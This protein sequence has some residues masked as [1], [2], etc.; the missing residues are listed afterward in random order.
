M[1]AI[2]VD[3]RIV[4]AVDPSIAESGWALF[5]REA[6]GHTLLAAG[7]AHLPASWRAATRTERIDAM[8]RQIESEAA[9]VAHLQATDCVLERPVVRN[10]AS[11]GSKGDPNDVLLLGILCG[12]I[13]LSQHRA[14]VRVTMIKPEE[15]KGQTPK[16]ISVERSQ[17]R[18]APSELARVKLPTAKG[19]AHNVWDAVGIGLWATGRI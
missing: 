6:A 12:A 1:P 11:S 7:L 15:W 9:G 16:D 2:C 17:A 13:A 14:G 3:S 5:V 19:L 18:L 10:A 8:V 4:L